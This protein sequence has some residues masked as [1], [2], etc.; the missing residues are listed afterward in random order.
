MRVLLGLLACACPPGTT[1]WNPAHVAS[2]DTGEGA[3]EP[4]PLDWLADHWT[5]TYAACEPVDYLV[6]FE[7]RDSTYFDVGCQAALRADLGVDVSTF[8]CADGEDA[9]VSLTLAAYHVLGS[10]FG[11]VADLRQ[12]TDADTRWTVREPFVAAIEAVEEHQGHGDVRGDLYDLVAS[13]IERTVYTGAEDPDRKDPV[14]SYHDRT[15]TV[16]DRVGYASGWETV[17]ILAHEA[18]HGWLGAW[19]VECPEDWVTFLGTDY[20]GVSACDPDWSG[21]HGFGAATARLVMDHIPEDVPE[22]NADMIESDCDDMIDSETFFIID[23][24]T[25]PPLPPP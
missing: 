3:E 5:S 19:H 14:A 6:S 25:P 1:P 15:L 17:S 7:E 4:Y 18:A 23:L 2:D 22:E 12:A 9:L 24:D 11:A 20:S 16:T 8:A 13:T 10:P 21:A